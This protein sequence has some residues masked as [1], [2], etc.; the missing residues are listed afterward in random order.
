HPGQ[1]FSFNRTVGPVTTER[2]FKF[3]P[4]ISGGTVIMG[5]GGG[6]CQVSSTLYNAVLQ[7][8]YQVVER[9]PHSKP[10][11]Y[12]PRGRDATISYHLDFKFRNNTDSF[13][14]IK[15]SIWGGRVQIQL[16]SST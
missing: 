16:L 3:A 1:V 8:G 14:L 10:V 13:V 4:V 9:Y 6:L 12:V 15:G 2:G 7:A 5:L 11:G